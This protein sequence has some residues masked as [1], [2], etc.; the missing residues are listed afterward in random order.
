[1]LPII[2]LLQSS[3]KR[4]ERAD[5][6]YAVVLAPTKE[7]AGQL[8]EE[9]CRVTQHAFHFVVPGVLSGG[10]KKAS[11]KKSLRK[12]VTIVVG[13]PGRL[14]DHLRS[15]KSFRV[16]RIR[17]IVLDE[18]DRLLD[19][20]FEHDLAA[21]VAVL[22]ERAAAPDKIQ[23]IMTSATWRPNDSRT[24]MRVTQVSDPLYIDADLEEQLVAEA[25]QSE[26]ANDDDVFVDDVATETADDTEIADEQLASQVLSMPSQ[27]QQHYMICPV[28]DRL[29]RFSVFFS[30]PTDNEIRWR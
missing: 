4:I 27:L 7:L 28:K 12:G 14:L 26:K 20:G 8:Y 19:A 1:M 13:T 30:C 9:A 17:F 2:D 6:A 10:R 29:V 23:T 11:E 5:G 18:A 15:T 3:E 22:R 16:S 25:A 21:I 24:A